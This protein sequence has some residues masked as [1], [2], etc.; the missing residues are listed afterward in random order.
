MNY[1]IQDLANLCDQPVEDMIRHLISNFGDVIPLDNLQ[2][3]SEIDHETANATISY[4]GAVIEEFQ[5][6]PQSKVENNEAIQV[7]ATR[8]T[9]TLVMNIDSI[10]QVLTE[11]S[12]TLGHNSGAVAAIAFTQNYVSGFNDVINPVVDYLLTEGDKQLNTIDE[13]LIETSAQGQEILGKLAVRKTQL[14]T[15]LA[16]LKARQRGLTGKIQG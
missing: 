9:Q 1:T 10:T 13:Q 14:D 5:I 15:R 2:A 7:A 16:Q 4:F 6:I 8:L 11:Q 3:A 12:K